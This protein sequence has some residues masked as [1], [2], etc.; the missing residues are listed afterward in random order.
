MQN[1][2]IWLIVIVHAVAFGTGC[3][4]HGSHKKIGATTGAVLGA[5]LG[6]IGLVIVLISPQKDVNDT[7]VKLQKYKAM[8]DKGLITEAEYS[9][10]RGQTLEEQ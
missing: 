10:L 1:N 4:F 3:G 8:F 9:N 7:A 2:Q 6:I 5:L